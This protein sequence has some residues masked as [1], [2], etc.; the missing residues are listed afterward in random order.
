MKNLVFFA[1]VLFHISS[2]AQPAYT[3]I[4]NDNY[5]NSFMASYNPSTIVDSKTK[6]SLHTE[7]NNSNI[8]NFVAKNYLVYGNVNKYLEPKNTGYIKKY[9][10]S[11][12][13]NFKYEFNHKNAAAYSFRFRSFRDLLGVPEM[14]AH[15]STLKYKENFYGKPT[16]ITGLTHTQLTFNEHNFTYARTIFDKQTSFLKAGASF[17]I[18]NGISSSYFYANSGSITFSDT[19]TSNATFTNL[20]GQLGASESNNQFIYKNRGLGLDLGVTYEYRPDYE[21]QYYDMDGAKRLVRYD[22]NKYKWKVSASITDIGFVRFINDSSS[23]YNFTNPSQQVN[24]SSIVNVDSIFYNPYDYIQAGVA[25]LGFK[26]TGGQVFKYRM[27]LPT[28][29][30]ANFDMNVFKP[31]FF[32]SYNVSIPLTLKNDVTKIKGYFIH[33]VTPRVEK[34]KW[35]VMLPI[36]Q[37]GNGRVYIG[38]AGRFMYKGFTFFAGSNNLSFYYGKKSS[39]T[40]NFFVGASYSVFYKVP[41]DTDGDK[42]SDERD[43]CPFDPGLPEFNGC[44]DT[45]G[46]GI[47]DKEDLCIYD[48]GPKRTKGCPDTDEDGI[49]D[50]NDMCPNEKGLG[51][52]YGC[53]DRDMDG[54]IDAAD[55]CPDEPGVELNNGCPIENKGCCLDQDGDGI[56]DEKDKCPTVPGSVYNSGCPID[57]SNINKINLPK[58]KEQKDANNTGQQVKD[59]PTIDPRKQLITSKDALDSLLASKKI[60]KNLSVYFDVDEATL[61]STEQQSFDNFMKTLPKNEKFEIL[62]IGYTDRDGSLDYNL[63]LSKRRAETV[64]RKLIDVYKFDPK[65]ISIYY[66][67]ESKSIHKGD[68]TDE[69]KKAD[70]RVDVKVIRVPKPNK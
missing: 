10:T 53:P 31:M 69:M 3:G 70:R 58:E 21:K 63:A 28:T 14:W 26:T 61:T 52:H 48:K 25:S 45:D 7:S 17:K 49:I 66:Y 32:V 51:I 40:R 11:D 62:L 57:S 36:S 4:V 59:N 47:M 9:L 50:M 67:G 54:V 13:L 39:L 44:P 2:F 38:G 33:T 41:K 56:L 29:F 37:M 19:N 18:L 46:D 35:S 22:I 64:Q 15:N 42:I 12:I 24:A 5:V 30:H 55:R 20:D 8:S 60:S 68:Y 34:E 1:F 23:Y 6:F 16:D 43:N 27:N 65:N